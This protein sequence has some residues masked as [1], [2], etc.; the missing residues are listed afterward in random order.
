M[1]AFLVVYV[2]DQIVVAQIVDGSRGG[3]GNQMTVRQSVM[4]AMVNTNSKSNARGKNYKKDRR[5]LV[6]AC[7]VIED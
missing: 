6:I 5:S 1:D 2:R 3:E 7:V 4:T